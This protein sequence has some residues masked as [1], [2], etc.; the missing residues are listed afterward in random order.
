MAWPQISQ[1]LVGGF[2]G[3][4]L[5]TGGFSGGTVAPT[6]ATLSGPTSGYVGQASDLFTITL[7]APAEVGGVSCTITDSVSNGEITST[8][9]VIAAGQSSG[10][11]T[12]TAGTAG[13]R[14][15]ALASTSP[16]LAIAGSPI[17][18]NATI[19]YGLSV[20]PARLNPSSTK[21]VTFLGFNTTWNSTPPTISASGAPTADGSWS[22]GTLTVVNDTTATRSVT[23]GTTRGTVTWTD[24]TTSKTANMTVAP[25]SNRGELVAIIKKKRLMRMR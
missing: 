11:F 4:C 19:I 15:I 1:I 12:I 3:P 5:L 2:E 13:N 22:I 17:T 21:T 7:D 10:T 25:Q 9:V 20:N 23:T 24:S 16:V 14:T 6:T 8:P 18:Y